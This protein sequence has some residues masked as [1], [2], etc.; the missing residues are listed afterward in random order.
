MRIENYIVLFN[1]VFSEIWQP[2]EIVDIS[3]SSDILFQY[4][5]TLHIVFYVKHR[6]M[7]STNFDDLI[8][9]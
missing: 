6:V 3:F 9:L 7:E 5:V 8:L 1:K 4:V 2:K